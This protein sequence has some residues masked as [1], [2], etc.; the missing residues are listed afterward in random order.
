MR[1]AY[2]MPAMW[3]DRGPMPYTRPLRTRSIDPPATPTTRTSTLRSAVACDATRTYDSDGPPVADRG[4]VGRR[5]ADLDHDRVGHAGVPQRARDRRRRT[6]VQRAHGRRAET[7][8]D[9]SRR[10][11][12]ASP[13]R[14][15]RSPA[16]R[17]P[18]ATNDAVRHRDRQDRRVERGG[19]RPQLQAVQAAELGRGAHGQA[20]LARR[21]RRPPSRS[22]GRRARTPRRRT[23]RRRPLAEP[24]QRLPHRRSTGSPSVTSK[25]AWRTRS[26]LPGASSTSRSRVRFSTRARSGRRPIPI[27]PTSAASPSSSAFTACVVECVTSSMLAAPTWVA[28]AATAA[29]TPAA[30]PACGGVG[31]R[32]DRRGDDVAACRARWR[33]P[34]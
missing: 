18:S 5:A 12:C 8:P 34:S 25:K 19:D 15:P 31:R 16:A 27:T 21:S 11:R 24:S 10:R 26:R 6:R 22:S 29:T 7:R 30:T 20:D 1:L 9:R 23:P 4:D 14:V 17:T 33:P 3:A 32:H 2:C 28:R 13:S